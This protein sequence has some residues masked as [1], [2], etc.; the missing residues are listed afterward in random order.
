M[1]NQPTRPFRRLLFA[2]TLVAA[3]LLAALVL[4]ELSARLG[5]WRMPAPGYDAGQSAQD[6]ARN[7]AI[8]QENQARAAN[9]PFGFNDSARSRE[10]T[11]GITKRIAVLGDSFVWGDGLAYGQ[12]WPKK[13]ESLFAGPMPHLEVLSWGRQGWSTADELAFLQEH[14]SRFDIDLLIVG[15]VTNDPDLGNENLK[16]IDWHRILGRSARL[17]PGLAS[18]LENRLNNFLYARLLTGWGYAAWEQN[19]YSPKNLADYQALLKDFKNTCQELNLPLLF[20]L[21]PTSHEPYYG[22]LIDKAI[23]LFE[24]EGI[25]YLNLYPAA[26]KKF[27]GFP[28]E[29]LRAN[30]ANPHP[31]PVLTEFFSQEV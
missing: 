6:I 19:L 25:D 11:P 9:H 14:G 17:F 2:M 20:V 26:A 27:G 28:L 18:L 15:F 21:T 30:P 23:P 12:A 3:G 16:S 1:S 22:Q 31:G 5:L 29:A 10:K 24:T 8:N 4:L 7:R 13:L